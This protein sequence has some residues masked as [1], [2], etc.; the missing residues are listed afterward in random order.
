MV[1]LNASFAAFGSSEQLLTVSAVALIASAL[2]GLNLV[3]ELNFGTGT[4]HCLA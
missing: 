3:A 1:S 2:I 4:P